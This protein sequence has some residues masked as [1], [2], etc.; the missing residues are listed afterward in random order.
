MDVLLTNSRNEMSP[1]SGVR[2]PC[3]ERRVFIIRQCYKIPTGCRM[4]KACR[5]YCVTGRQS[6]SATTSPGDFLPRG[7]SAFL[8]VQL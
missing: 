5:T 4:M 3:Y 6:D 2:W 8:L 7:V 1:S